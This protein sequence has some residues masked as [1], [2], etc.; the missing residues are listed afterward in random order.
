MERYGEGKEGER[1]KRGE[2][3]GKWR[4]GRENVSGREIYGT[5]LCFVDASP[6]RCLATNRV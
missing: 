3:G 1:G 5:Q 2:R 4:E 6:K